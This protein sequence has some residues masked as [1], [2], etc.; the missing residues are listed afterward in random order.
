M[1]AIS[2]LPTLYKELTVQDESIDAKHDRLLQRNLVKKPYLKAHNPR[3]SI[4]R[5]RLVNDP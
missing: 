3:K 2:T 5:S 1:F 4:Y